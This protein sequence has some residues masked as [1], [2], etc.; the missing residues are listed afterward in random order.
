M[1][2][3]PTPPAQPSQLASFNIS[4][5]TGDSLS[6]QF[7]VDAP[8]LSVA[9]NDA[10]KNRKPLLLATVGRTG[11]RTSDSERWMNRLTP[12]DQRQYRATAVYST[13]RTES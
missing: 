13:A 8:R 11:G 12:T 9:S 3:A 1:T 6:A 2:T 4:S 5:H 7:C 10:M